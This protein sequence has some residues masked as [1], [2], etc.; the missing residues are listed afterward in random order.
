MIL[1]L[2][3]NGGENII[4]YEPQGINSIMHPYIKI[5]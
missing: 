5:N 4:Q 2:L 3:D 1:D